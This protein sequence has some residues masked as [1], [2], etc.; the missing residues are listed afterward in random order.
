MKVLIKIGL[1][2]IYKCKNIKTIVG[3]S[4]KYHAFMSFYLIIGA[5]IAPIIKVSHIKLPRSHSTYFRNYLQLS[6]IH[7][8]RTLIKA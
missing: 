5:N 1:I 6:H 7:F 2:E 8:V 4:K 3:I